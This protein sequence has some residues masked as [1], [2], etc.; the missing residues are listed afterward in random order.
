MGEIQK[1][2]K[3]PFHKF[4]ER[5]FSFKML[6]LS[7]SSRHSN[8][9]KS[10]SQ[11]YICYYSKCL[12]SHLIIIFLFIFRLPALLDLID[13]HIIRIM[14]TFSIYNSSWTVRLP[15]RTLFYILVPSYEKSNLNNFRFFNT[16]SI[17]HPSSNVCCIIPSSSRRCKLREPNLMFWHFWRNFSYSNNY[18]DFQLSLY[19]E[20]I[21]FRFNFLDYT[22]THI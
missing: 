20:F 5:I 14:Y 7:L 1:L 10:Q 6:P 21:S 4:L 13:L 22:H 15:L 9:N 19:V 18:F 12:L 16:S 17:V 8:S 11:S 3:I 2:I